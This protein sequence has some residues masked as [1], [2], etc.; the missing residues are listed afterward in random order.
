MKRITSISLIS[1]VLIVGLLSGACGA[2]PIA[3]PIST[4]TPGVLDATILKSTLS[5]PRQILLAKNLKPLNPE[6]ISKIALV[7]NKPVT[8]EQPV[9]AER[10][11]Q[12]AVGGVIRF[13]NIDLN[14]AGFVPGQIIA[15]GITVE[16]PYGLLRKVSS[17]NPID[18]NTVDLSTVQATL[19]DVID[20]GNISAGTED[21]ILA[22]DGNRSYAKGGG[23]MMVISQPLT[24]EIVI[25]IKDVALVDQGQNKKLIAKGSIIIK[26]EFDLQIRMESFEVKEFLFNNKS[27]ITADVSVNSNI[28]IV[29]IKPKVKLYEYPFKPITKMVGSLPVVITPILNVY[30]GFDGK[31]SAGFTTGLKYTNTLERGMYWKDGDWSRLEPPSN[32]VFT[33]IAPAIKAIASAKVYI[34]PHLEILLYGV[35]GPY[36]DIDGYILLSASP[37]KDPWWELRG[38]VTAEVGV[39]FKMFSFLKKLAARESFEIYNEVFA[40]A[41]SEVV[42]SPA[43]PPPATESSTEIPATETSQASAPPQETI[44]PKPS[45]PVETG[46]EN[47]QIL[48]D[49][50]SLN[51]INTS[52][53]DITVRGIVF[54]R[55][56]NQGNVTASYA[57]DMWGN[58]YAGYSP[59]LPRYCLRIALPNSARSPD[60]IEQVNFETSQEKY[61]FWRAT[62]DSNKFQ[63]WKNG[64][65]LQTC[66]ISA[67]SCSFYLP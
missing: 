45:S 44:P 37:Q 17:V 58:F 33:P 2:E 27:K 7:G 31:V 25:K 10:L 54:K 42:E 49:N 62:S 60:C 15:T 28:D 63:V 50:T 22:E 43:T 65:L 40:Q 52:Q 30:V 53:N 24:N 35:V 67:G 21:M 11:D 64:T 5:A 4:E 34:Q 19:E 51:M 18:N 46:N 39:E 13:S 48:Y 29:D 41:P 8:A 9:T 6:L 36:A 12:L 66:E 57:A 16:T 38:V 3:E 47:I 14:Q 20:S 56:D 26:P 32:P 55:I 1:I 59:L 23:Q 61:H